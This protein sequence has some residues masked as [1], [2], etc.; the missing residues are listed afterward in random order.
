MPDQWQ[1]FSVYKQ[2]FPHYLIPVSTLFFH[3]YA[4][5]MHNS[6][7]FVFY[8][9]DSPKK[10]GIDFLYIQHEMLYYLTNIL[11]R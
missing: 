7:F 3:D 1:G 9:K 11:C 6:L 4:D 5:R 2:V 8:D 10:T